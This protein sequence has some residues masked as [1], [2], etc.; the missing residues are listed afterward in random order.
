QMWSS[1]MYATILIISMMETA[2][3][4]YPHFLSARSLPRVLL[5]EQLHRSVHPHT[6]HPI[7]DDEFYTSEDP[8]D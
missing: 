5:R 6:F 7:Q 8:S 1:A 3:L 4:H 2:P